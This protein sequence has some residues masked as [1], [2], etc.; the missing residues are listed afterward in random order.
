M[1]GFRDLVAWLTG[2][3]SAGEGPVRRYRTVAGQVWHPGAVAAELSVSGPS[4]G[5]TH[6]C[7]PAAGQVH[8]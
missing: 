2:W 4:A 5:Q 7:G 8:G 3:K 1:A 6:S